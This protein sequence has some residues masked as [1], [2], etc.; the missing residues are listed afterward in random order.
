MRAM[1]LHIRTRASAQTGTQPGTQPS[2][3]NRSSVSIAFGGLIAM[4]I[5]IGIGRFVYTP[6]LPPMMA[7]LG[8]SKSAAGL[9][10]SANFLG[11][12]A[13]A[14]A[15]TRTRLPG[16]QL[17]WLPGALAL[18]A[19]T[20]GAMGLTGSMG[21][22]LVLRFLGGVASALI[23][24]LSSALVLEHLARVGRPR[25][26]SLHFAGVGSGI[27]VSA[28]LVAV[29]LSR[30]ANWDSMWL[31]S[32]A[33]S[34]L[35]AVAVTLL[36][37]GQTPAAATGGA[38][39]RATG[40]RR[41]GRMI[42]AYGL[43]GFGY[44]ITATFLVAIVRTTPAISGLEPVIWVMVGMAAAPS[45]MLWTFVAGRIGIPRAFATAA[46]TEAAGVLASVV[47]PSAVGISVAAVLVG[48][49]FMGLT[50]LGLMRGREL[51]PGN[52]RPVMAAM[53][54]AFG[55]GQ[56]VGPVLAGVAS[57][58]L[59]GFAIPSLAAAGALVLAA[60]LARR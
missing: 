7:A 12:L 26:A 57:D 36:L 1:M 8:L 14:V 53:T 47:W 13:G 20:T 5:G 23:L 28:V 46:L 50:A 4:A 60:W 59:E 22:F 32:G 29:Q 52:P 42:V 41:L 58:I 43:F 35:G 21:G 51:A 25:L 45:V 16:P 37:S 15:A 30:G 55:V 39:P 38:V 33:L 44:V 31:A 48:G 56:I 10:A 18:S 6:I 11:Y 40:D 17:L 9:I 34:L 27:A 3:G 54:G 49:T 24:I 19:V 2:P